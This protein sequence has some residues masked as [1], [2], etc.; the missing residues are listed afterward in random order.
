MGTESD[1]RAS[2]L[3]TAQEGVAVPEAEDAVTAWLAGAPT[4]RL[5]AAVAARLRTAIA[6]EVAARGVLADDPDLVF[7]D[8][9]D[10]LDGDSLKSD[11]D[12]RDAIE[13]TSPVSPS[14]GFEI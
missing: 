3:E 6:D 5:P 1:P 10:L 2:N 9:D 8:T 14:E 12:L 4:L 13:L 7:S 11:D